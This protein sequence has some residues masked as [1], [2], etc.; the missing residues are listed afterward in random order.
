MS[1]HSRTAALTTSLLLLLAGCN[2][3]P[4]QPSPAPKPTGVVDICGSQFCVNGKS[5][6]FAGWNSPTAVAPDGCSPDRPDPTQLI[7]AAKAAHA[8]V[9]RFWLY[10][11]LTTSGRD[12]SRLDA[13]VN[14]AQQSGVY[15]LPVFEDGNAIKATTWHPPGTAD[16]CGMHTRPRPDIAWFR[17]GYKK[18]YSGFP[19]SFKDYVSTTV[20][21]Y[22]DQKAIFGWML[23]NEP[24]ADDGSCD[25][26]FHDFFKDMTDTVAT[27]DPNHL[28]TSGSAGPGTNGFN[29]DHAP[30]TYADIF[31]LPHNDFLEYHDYT[32][33]AAKPP[34]PP[35]NPSPSFVPCDAPNTPAPCI[36]PGSEFATGTAKRIGKPIIIGEI[37][38]L[39]QDADRA[40]EYRRRFQAAFRAGVTGVLPWE[41][42]LAPSPRLDSYWF[43]PGDPVLSV[44]AEFGGSGP[45]P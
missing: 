20:G 17:N 4:F 26:A 11:D 38:I 43:G 25:P 3:G 8:S 15:L 39:R 21:H 6:R 7:A 32:D 44:V 14:A 45:G 18:P 19:T 30:N 33:P 34:S 41:F 36:D 16:T 23:M 1:R 24:V 29:C 12:F 28:V 35:A 9:I 5:F 27:N 31:S 2:F 40:A 10:Q 37:G 13:L 42:A 22:K